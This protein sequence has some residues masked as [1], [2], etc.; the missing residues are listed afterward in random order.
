MY[1]ITF[2]L[3]TSQAIPVFAFNYQF[4]SCLSSLLAIISADLNGVSILTHTSE[5]GS[6]SY[7]AQQELVNQLFT[8]T[9]TMR[10]SSQMAQFLSQSKARRCVGALHGAVAR[11]V[12]AL[13]DY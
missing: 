3:N 12:R 4:G 1:L 10:M 2:L 9:I 7:I 5:N 6:L 8:I 11:T 13:S